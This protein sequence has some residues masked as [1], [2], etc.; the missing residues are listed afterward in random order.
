MLGTLLAAHLDSAVV[1]TQQEA[2]AKKSRRDFI[3]EGPCRIVLGIITIPMMPKGCGLF[4]I[5]EEGT[6]PRGHRIK[7]TRIV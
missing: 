2:R 4:P 7:S 3:L 5:A 6:V 1:T